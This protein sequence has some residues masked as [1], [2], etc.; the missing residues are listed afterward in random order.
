MA[1]LKAPEGVTSASFGGVQYDADADGMID[2]VPEAVEALVAHGFVGA[3][4]APDVP[5]KKGKAAQELP[6]AQ[7]DQA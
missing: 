3:P 2:V 7:V 6:P 5:T 1:R 4:D